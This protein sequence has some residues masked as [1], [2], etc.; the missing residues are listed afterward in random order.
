MRIN[1]LRSALKDLKSQGYPVNIRFPATK[2]ELMVEYNR[3][4]M[5]RKSKGISTK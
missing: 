3:I 2:F 4:L 1:E 5:L